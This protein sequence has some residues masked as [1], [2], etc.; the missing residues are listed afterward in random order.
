LTVDLGAIECSSADKPNLYLYPTANTLTTVVLKHDARQEVFA[1]EPAYLDGWSGM[2]HP[3]GT[4]SVTPGERSPFLFYEISLLPAQVA[5]FQHT[6]AVCI[7]GPG[8]VNAM[9]ALL[10][11][12]GFNAREQADFV[13]GWVDDMPVR[14][15]YAVYP[16]RNVEGAVH[17]GI[18]P[19]LPLERLWL[20]VQDGAGCTPSN[21]PIVP[22]ARPAGH[23]VEWGVVLR[24]LR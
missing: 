6:N 12:C 14:D 8:A 19:E 17:V 9:A 3:D 7:D 23:A 13:D 20:V 18:E 10:G 22:I 5:A 15:S 4:F 11:D 2:A 21:A 24:G 16:Q 1:S